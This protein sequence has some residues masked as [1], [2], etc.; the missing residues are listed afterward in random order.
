MG[1]AAGNA[2]KAG[3]PGHFCQPAGSHGTPPSILFQDLGSVLMLEGRWCSGK[4]VDGCMSRNMSVRLLWRFCR[5]FCLFLLVF[6]GLLPGP[7]EEGEDRH[8]REFGGERAMVLCE[9]RRWRHE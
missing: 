6:L 5:L 4:G 7:L 1:K 3:W 2:R 8:N 9:G